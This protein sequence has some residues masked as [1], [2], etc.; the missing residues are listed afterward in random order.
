MLRMQVLRK[1]ASPGLLERPLAACV[2]VRRRGGGGVGEKEE[3]KHR[4]A[5]FFFSHS[6]VPYLSSRGGKTR[7][8][9]VPRLT[10]SMFRFICDES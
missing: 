7:L 10:V 4:D 6:S 2:V 3:K 5:T 1:L 8:F 9:F